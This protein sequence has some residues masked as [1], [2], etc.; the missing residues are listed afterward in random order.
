MPDDRPSL[1]FQEDL[2]LKQG[3]MSIQISSRFTLDRVA[4]GD[5]E[6]DL[7]VG[8]GCRPKS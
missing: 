7:T 8:N 2:R 3:A 6:H 5:L 4:D 1:S